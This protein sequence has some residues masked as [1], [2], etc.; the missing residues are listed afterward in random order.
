MRPSPSPPPPTPSVLPDSEIGPWG[1]DYDPSWDQGYAPV[2]SGP[3]DRYA[4]GRGDPG[5]SDWSGESGWNAVPPQGGPSP[6]ASP[7][8]SLSASRHRAPMVPLDEIAAMDVW[9]DDMSMP[10][11]TPAM[12]AQRMVRKMNN[13]AFNLLLVAL[14]LGILGIPAYIGWQRVLQ[15]QP[16]ALPVA[17][18]VSTREPT[19][20]LRQGFVGFET[21][22]FTVAYPATWTHNARTQTLN[23]RPLDRQEFKGS[24]DNL[25]VLGTTGSVP[26]DQLRPFLES[27]ARQEFSQ[28]VLQPNATDLRPTYDHER[29]IEE[30][31][32]VTELQGNTN[33]VVQTRVLVVN[34]GTRTYFAII[35]DRKSAFQADAAR[36]SEP[37][38][39]SFRFQTP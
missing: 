39:A 7:S 12:R 3:Y 16:K 5:P 21:G 9:Q 17:T 20:A 36:Y 11:L 15:L 22:A 8:G 25:V 4:Q 35:T 10:M 23:D 24:G 37:M 34:H 14:V 30:D 2:S 32:T 27:L 28:W 26:S 33:V 13:T 19:P 18:T 38:L 1:S 6:V 29:W 31:Y